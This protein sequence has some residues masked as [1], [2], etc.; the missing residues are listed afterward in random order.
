MNLTISTEPLPELQKP[1][2]FGPSAFLLNSPVPDPNQGTMQDKINPPAPVKKHEETS[3]L[4]SAIHEASKA[5][6]AAT[7]SQSQTIHNIQN[8]FNET[9][10]IAY[11]GLCY[12]LLYNYKKTRFRPFQKKA[13]ASFE[14]W[15]LDFMEKMFVYM[16]VLDAG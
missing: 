16:D 1:N 2:E 11:V 13:L 9:Q 4:P 14:R 8:V 3:A 6:V 7:L 10:K 12:T 15:S 5:V